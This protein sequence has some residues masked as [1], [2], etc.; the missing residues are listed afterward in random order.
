MQICSQWFAIRICV[1]VENDICIC[2][3]LQKFTD[4]HKYLY[5]VPYPRTSDNN[6]IHGKTE[7]IND[8]NTSIFWVD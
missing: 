8:H 1:I 4:I 7:S 2:P 5:A 3:Y 6:Q